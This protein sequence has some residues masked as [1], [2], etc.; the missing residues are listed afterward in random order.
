MPKK[1]EQEKK[2]YTAKQKSGM[3]MSERRKRRKKRKKNP[4]IGAFV[5][6]VGGM[7]VSLGAGMIVNM[8]KPTTSPV[9]GSLIHTGAQA[10]LFLA[11][12]SDVIDSLQ[13]SARTGALW[14]FG[15]GTGLSG[16]G[17]LLNVKN[18][19]NLLPR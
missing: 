18:N 10:G 13:G 5:G 1:Q 15:L 7:A 6:F 2:Q 19:S 14:A 4:S 12:K 17:L 3:I 11:T 9:V 8:L 16:Y